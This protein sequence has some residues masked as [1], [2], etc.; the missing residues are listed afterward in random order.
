MNTASL[1]TWS[2]EQIFDAL[3]QAEVDWRYEVIWEWIAEWRKENVSFI[4]TFT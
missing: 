2:K 3:S 4:A 1:S